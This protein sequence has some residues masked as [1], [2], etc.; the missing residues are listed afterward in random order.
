MHNV[1]KSFCFNC[2]WIRHTVSP[3]RLSLFLFPNPF[4]SAQ[5]IGGN[6]LMRSW[7]LLLSKVLP[8]C[9]TSPQA[10]PKAEPLCTFTFSGRPDGPTGEV[11]R[12]AIFN[13]HLP[14]WQ[15][16]L[17]GCFISSRSQILSAFCHCQ[18][19]GKKQES[20]TL[21]FKGTSDFLNPLS[22]LLI[23]LQTQKKHT[24]QRSRGLNLHPS[25]CSANIYWVATEYV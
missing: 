20:K 2:C 17:M 23:L 18:R 14:R 7:G 22:T 12:L 21:S 11:V 6:I 3:T 9:P 15:G 4:A 13:H 24:R 19:V 16:T 25:M 10:A 8:S 5:S 1:L